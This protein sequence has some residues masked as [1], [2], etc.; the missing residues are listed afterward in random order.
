MNE[1]QQL[2]ASCQAHMAN[3]DGNLSRIAALMGDAPKAEQ[4]EPPSRYFKEGDT[5]WM[6]AGDGVF[7]RSLNAKQVGWIRAAS[8]QD[9]IINTVPEIT[10]EQAEAILKGGGL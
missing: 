3:I 8:H 7:V 10:A 9:Y 1:V 2:I 6:I 4:P 5:V